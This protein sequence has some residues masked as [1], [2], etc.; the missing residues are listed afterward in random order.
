MDSYVLNLRYFVSLFFSVAA[1]K[2]FLAAISH[3]KIIVRWL[4]SGFIKTT[5]A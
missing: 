2:R 1:E 5:K 3:K 4:L